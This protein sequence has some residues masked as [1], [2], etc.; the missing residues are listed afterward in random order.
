MTKCLF[1]L[2]SILLATVST[3]AQQANTK[4]YTYEDYCTDNPHAPTCV[5]GKPPA[6]QSM[7]PQLSQATQ[8]AGYCR[9]NAKVAGC[10]QYCKQN[11][12]AFVCIDTKPQ[13]NP[14][15]PSKAQQP[16]APVQPA[17]DPN[18]PK[19]VIIPDPPVEQLPGSKNLSLPA[20]WRFAHPHPDMMMAVNLTAL[21][22]SPAAQSLI[23]QLTTRLKMTP[24]ELE[25][26]LEKIKGVDH[27][28]ASFDSGDT[29]ILLQGKMDY[30][31]GFVNLG[32]GLTCYRISKTAVVLGHE[33]SVAAAVQRLQQKAG[34]EPADLE[35][36]KQLGGEID[37]WI[38]GTRA[39]LSKL[40]MTAASNAPS[41]YLLAASFH[42]GLRIDLQLNYASADEAR[43]TVD[44]LRSSPVSSLHMSGEIEGTTVRVSF[45]V[46][47]AEVSNAV[48]KVM[49]TPQGKRFLSTVDESIHNPDPMVVY[50]LAGGPK[51]LPPSATPPPPP[52][53]MVIYGLPSGPRVL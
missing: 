10:E 41:S 18:A 9:T 26:A 29:L 27:Y 6:A 44:T 21:R 32:D 50:G 2:G 38:Q 19:F 3:S 49:A 16:A 46:D 35:Q 34:A 30:P 39:M 7:T 36:V 31:T 48:G 8:A 33:A 15:P 5:N 13:S 25:A 23:E 20:S 43:R 53:K 42:D 11:P 28:W 47:R 14:A 4:P 17:V 40:K 24:G 22:K 52:G 37:L 51:V 12:K 45:A 1:V